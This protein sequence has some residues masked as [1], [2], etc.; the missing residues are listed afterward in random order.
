MQLRGHIWAAALAASAL[1]MGCDD[2]GDGGETTDESLGSQVLVT[3][4]EFD[5]VPLTQE[6][7]EAAGWT[8]TE[9]CVPG[10]GVH[11]LNMNEQGEPG[12]LVLLYDL[13]GRLLGVELESLAEQPAPPWEHLEEGHEGM[14][15]EH[16]TFHA[17]FRDPTGVCEG[18]VAP[19]ADGSVGHRL[20]TTHGQF[21]AMPHRMGAAEDA[22][23]MPEGEC[24]PN[25]G[26]HALRMGSQGEPEPLV[27]LYSPEGELIGF[28]LE[29]LAEQPSPP[30]EHLEEGHP[31]MEFEHWT[32]HTYFRD[33]RG[34][35]Q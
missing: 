32:F 14:E 24:V 10:M 16:W 2:N 8:S 19:P 15:F 27:L 9:E 30:W 11:A 12:P 1:A 35:C 3:Q 33:P 20:M 28:E 23:W 13:E 4:G 6:A 21:N 34:I 31:G 26:V 5:T 7:A 25:M 18:E 17:Y 22:G 29:S